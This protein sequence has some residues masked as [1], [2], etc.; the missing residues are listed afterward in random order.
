M[1]SLASLEDIR[2]RYN[3]PDES[4][5]NELLNESLIVATMHIESWLQTEFDLE[6]GVVEQFKLPISRPST[7][8]KMFPTFRLNNGFVSTVNSVKASGVRSELTA[9]T[10]ITQA[11]YVSTDL[12]R[13]FV[14]VDMLFPDNT[15]TLSRGMLQPTSGDWFFQIDYDK[16]FTTTT[17]LDGGPVFVGVPDWLAEVAMLVGKGVYDVGG[18]CEGDELL[19][20]PKG[21]MIQSLLMKRQRNAP[22]TVKPIFARV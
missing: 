16:G 13:G 22:Y 17:Q 21:G 19:K 9:S 5:V 8:N 3:L 11:D 4:V 15:F 20:G 2:L 14:S 6:A 10:A 18:S 12:I 1:G 7:H